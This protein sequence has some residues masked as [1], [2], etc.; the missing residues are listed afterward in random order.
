M[1]K[2]S[3]KIK[4]VIFDLDGTVSDTNECY[5]EAYKVVFGKL[6]IHPQDKDLYKYYGLCSLDLIKQ[7]VADF[8]GKAKM[9]DADF[10]KILDDMLKI[11]GN[12]VKNAEAV[13]KKNADAIKAVRALGIKTAIATGSSKSTIPLVLKENMKLFDF[14]ATSNDVK[15]GKPNPDIFLLCAQKLDA[16]PDECIAIG[17]TERDIIGAK[18]AKMIA[19]GVTTGP[20]TKENLESQKPYRVIDSLSDLTKIISDLSHL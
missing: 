9:T 20:C 3:T 1:A 4:A 7:V 17:D 15:R 8:N 11:Y 10:E 14:I 19:I 18:N 16:R 13:S 12:K 2:L 5:L 6:G